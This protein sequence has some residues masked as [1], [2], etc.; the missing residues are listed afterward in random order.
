M[1]FL[2]TTSDEAIDKKIKADVTKFVLERLDK[3]RW[4]QRTEEEKT[5]EIKLTISNLLNN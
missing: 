1:K 3:K 2:E 5:G 4:S